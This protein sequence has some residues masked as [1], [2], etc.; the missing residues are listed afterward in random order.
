MVAKAAI[1][2]FVNYSEPVYQHALWATKQ[3]SPNYTSNSKTMH[4]DN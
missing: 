1:F 2:L 4:V 3:T